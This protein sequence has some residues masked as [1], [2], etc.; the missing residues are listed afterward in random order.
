MTD[1]WKPE[2]RLE[3]MMDMA[4]HP[5][6]TA[7]VFRGGTRMTFGSMEDFSPRHDPE[8]IEGEFKV[9]ES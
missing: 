1:P 2:P 7:Y 3:F 8:V 4:A 5:D 6:K 9:V